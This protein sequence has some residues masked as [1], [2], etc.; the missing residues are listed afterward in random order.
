MVLD[1][2]ITDSGYEEVGLTVEI[3]GTEFI[4]YRCLDSADLF[5]KR[6]HLVDSVVFC[7]AP[8]H[9][10]E[11]LESGKL[12]PLPP[13]LY[14]EALFVHPKTNKEGEAD[15]TAIS[16]EKAAGTG[17]DHHNIYGKTF[18]LGLE[19]R[20]RSIYLISCA[21]S[22]VYRDAK[23][24]NFRSQLSWLLYNASNILVTGGKIYSNGLLYALRQWLRQWGAAK[25]NIRVLDIS[26]Q[27]A[28]DTTFDYV[29]NCPMFLRILN[30]YR[31]V[32][33]EPWDQGV[34][35]ILQYTGRNDAYDSSRDGE[36]ESQLLARISQF[37][38][39][40]DK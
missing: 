24:D 27:I 19:Q 29:R 32:Y 2:P 4:A 14:D 35:A 7:H 17:L 12:D 8:F 15:F 26:F 37:R 33:T 38:T 3:D 18:D 28:D 6:K 39:D 11:Y 31:F 1:A 40:A 34:G 10:G 36:M 21:F 23:Q 30:K 20:I 13:H 25:L 16:G 9:R 22:T 5:E